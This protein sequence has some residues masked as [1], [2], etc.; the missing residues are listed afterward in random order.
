MSPLWLL[1]A[2]RQSLLRIKNVFICIHCS[3]MPYWASNH[4]V[5][6][7]MSRLRSPGY[8]SIPLGHAIDLARKLHNQNR[9]NVIDREAAVREMGYSGMTGRSAKLLADLGHFGLVEKA[10]KGGIRV[11]QNAV[12]I[13]HQHSPERRR[14]ALKA[15]ASAPELFG[16]L[17]Q[18]WPD[19]IPSEHALQSYLMRESFASAAI[20]PAIGSFIETCRLLQQEGAFESHGDPEGTAIDSEPLEGDPSVGSE[21]QNPRGP[22]RIPDNLPPQGTVRIMEGERVVFVEES[23]PSH[24]LKVVASGELDADLLEALEDYVNRQKR[25]INQKAVAD[26]IDSLV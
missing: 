18:R 5:E 4:A 7:A 13:L 20:A 2:P 19:V 8:P 25:R 6:A 17:R 3:V 21:P 11:T 9:T 24:Y 23:H 26:D 14:E 10:G 1:P 15:A 16:Q 12:E 22:G